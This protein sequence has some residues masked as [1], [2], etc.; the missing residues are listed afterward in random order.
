MLGANE[1]RQ[2]WINFF[3]AKKH[4]Y[5]E[6]FSLVP[7]NDA[8]LL[9]I[10]SG[11]AAIK[12]YFV[13]ELPLPGKRLVN[14]QKVI[15]T[16][17]IESIGLT[18]RHHT[19]FEMLGNF[20]IGDY[21][22]EEAIK[23]AYEFLTKELKLNPDKLFFTVFDEDEETY[24]IYESFITDKTKIIKCGKD[25]NFW[26]MGSGPCGPC[27]E[28][29]YDRGEKYDPEKIGLKL[30]QE[31]IENER[32]LEIWN[33]VL[34]EYI[35]E[36]G[37][38]K[39]AKSK[40]IDTG[41][42]L[43]RL[44]TVVEGT[45]NNFE[46]SLFF[47]IIQE[48]EKFGQH[49]YTKNL[50]KKNEPDKQKINV[51][52]Q[53]ITDHLKATIMILNDGVIF[54]NKGREY[55]LR[56]LFRRAM[57]FANILKLDYQFLEASTE[58]IVE[59]FG[60]FYVD[61]HVNKDNI[62]KKIFKELLAF[63]EILKKTNKY[64]EKITEEIENDIEEKIFVMV[65]RHGIPFDLIK[66]ILLTKNIVFSTEKYDLLFEKHR[67]ASQNKTF[68][69]AFLNYG[70]QNN[71]VTEETIFDYDKNELSGEKIISILDENFNPVNELKDQVGF[72]IFKKTIFFPNIA[73][74]D[75]DVG[76]INDSHVHE[77]IKNN[78]QILHKV[79]SGHF[80]INDLVN[81]KINVKNRLNISKHHTA[82]HL[83]YAI[84]QKALS[85]NIT[86][87]SAKKTDGNF[88]ISLNTL[89]NLNL[90][91]LLLLQKMI[92]KSIQEKTKVETWWTD[93][94]GAKELGLDVDK[95][96][97]TNKAENKFRIVKIGN[98]SQELCVGT[99]VQN[100]SELEN[101]LIVS[102][103]KSGENVFEIIAITGNNLICEFLEK[104]KKILEQKYLY[105][106]SSVK[107][108][109]MSIEQELKT[110]WEK[111]LS[112]LATK[113]SIIIDGFFDEYWLEHKKKISL[114]LEEIDGLMKKIK[115]EEQKKLS[116]KLNLDLL[117]K[118]KEQDYFIFVNNHQ[119]QEL[120][121]LIKGF[122]AK[123][124]IK[125][126]LV[127]NEFDDKKHFYIIGE[128]NKV[129][130][131]FNLL[132]EQFNVHGGGKNLITGNIDKKFENE[133]IIKT[134]KE[135]IS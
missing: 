21:F 68:K 132:K 87:A 102:M 78:N 35:N 39:K 18:Y 103:N 89:N 46:N 75:N 8:S 119:P 25:R 9:F 100:C 57:V 80:K 71:N 85:G 101:F 42:G 48:I 107:N 123:E 69:N 77:V 113:Y 112:E 2:K 84:A 43:E 62:L 58:K 30:L 117:A 96:L 4:F 70:N 106:L 13:G 27:T 121:K 10:N 45:D 95:L 92:Q 29:Y 24:Q 127:F 116:S 26:D 16:N 31:D 81:L 51:Y 20:S 118:I 60:N 99:H 1:I 61:L 104:E 83:I 111:I 28:I 5:V 90:N 54:G 86:R 120:Y 32:Y 7:V 128:E 65:E 72:L 122:F 59:M 44:L 74:Q 34:S 37:V 22:K 38:F 105:F 3:K 64:L 73:G 23:M 98:I 97:K 49:K 126:F 55:V 76:Q 56:K 133:E 14:C 88:S 124:N 131:I 66:E 53:I 91:D 108:Y 41:A 33:I 93:L 82:E 15:R 12:K 50:D 67:L 52:F 110:K 40:N 11:I 114:L 47:P 109:V 115:G 130:E 134:I 6:P 79:N 17:D 125:Y 135:K 36:N 129:Q 63:S 94:I 19:F